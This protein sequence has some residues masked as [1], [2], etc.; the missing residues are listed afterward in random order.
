MWPLYAAC[1]ALLWGLGQVV[2]KR[3]LSYVSPATFL[4]VRAATDIAVWGP[5]ALAAGIHSGRP[6][7]VLA[8]AL[9]QA[10]GNVAGIEAL[11][12]GPAS[13][14]GT[15]GSAY[16]IATV[17]LA[18]LVLREPMR[19]LE[20]AAVA[21]LIAGTLLTSAPPARGERS[22][23]QLQ[24]G[25]RA[26]PW[27]LLSVAAL[28]CWG[29]VELM[30]KVCLPTTPFPVLLAANALSQLIL[31]G[32]YV[33]W[34]RVRGGPG[35]A[36]AA[37]LLDDGAALSD[38][39]AAF[40]RAKMAPLLIALAVGV[41]YTAGQWPYFLAL[42]SGPLRLTS[43]LMA[44]YPMVTAI[45]ARVFLGERL[46]ARQIT[47]VMLVLASSITIAALRPS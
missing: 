11:R 37:S 5:L 22:G 30:S 1:T 24:R 47:A 41:M 45:G 10:L 14:A 17:T 46:S 8:A 29:S 4:I 13:L 3:G 27:Q 40:R 32:S 28:M 33:A 39:G 16:P 35:A 26:I 38:S 43:P 34:P 25:R 23:L 20:A 19:P 18:V 44:G 31:T 6:G 12:R 36:R 2:E 21:G 7:L 15:V 9:C 42:G